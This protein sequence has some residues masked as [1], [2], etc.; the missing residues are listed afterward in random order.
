MD[1][2][3]RKFVIQEHKKG[4]D[5]HWDLM[6]ESD[7]ILITYR[8][9]K[10]PS[11]ILC[12]PANAKKIFDHP[13]KFLIYEGPVN[14]RQGNVCII[15]KGTYKVINQK[16]NRIELELNGKIF[17]GKFCLTNVEGNKWQFSVDRRE[18]PG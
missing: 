2:K 15:E 18:K 16:D 13:L 1:Q 5:I 7:D 9:D 11:E 3:D 14:K 10:S 17:K 12:Y 8:L 6:L 4:K